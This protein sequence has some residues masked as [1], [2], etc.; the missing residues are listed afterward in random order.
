[1]IKVDFNQY[2]ERCSQYVKAELVSK[3]YNDPHYGPQSW[4]ETYVDGVKVA[5]M[6]PHGA[7]YILSAQEE[8]AMYAEEEKE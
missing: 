4:L 1:M 2:V 7:C 8:D 3:T 5:K 6:S